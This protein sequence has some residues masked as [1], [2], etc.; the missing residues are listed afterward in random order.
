[1]EGCV[2][3]SFSKVQCMCEA[4]TVIIF[5]IVVVVVVSMS[6]RKRQRS[7]GVH[8]PRPLQ[9]RRPRGVSPIR[10]SRMNEP[11]YR[12]ELY[13][14][15]QN[16]GYPRAVI[17]GR[18][19][20]LAEARR[21]GNYIEEVRDFDNMVRAIRVER[22]G[23]IQR[24]GVSQINADYTLQV[25]RN[26]DA[27]DVS[28]LGAEIGRAMQSFVYRTAT[29]G[30]MRPDSKAYIELL[31]HN[32]R[33]IRS[34]TIKMSE[35]N[36]NDFLEYFERIL[37][38][39]DEA[40]FTNVVYRVV[41]MMDTRGGAGGIERAVPLND[42]VAQVLKKR[43]ILEIVSTPYTND[44]FLQCMCL[45]LAD[46]ANDSEKFVKLKKNRFTGATKDRHRAY[47]LSHEARILSEEHNL[48]HR[49]D[50]V[51]F[52]DI[53]GY[54]EK[55]NLRIHVLSLETC[56][57][58]RVSDRE[59][60]PLA[61]SVY[62][63]CFKVRNESGSA[64]P[65]LHYSYI[66]KDKVHTLWNKKYFC[67]KCLVPAAEERQ[68][69]CD[70]VCQMCRDSCC[71]GRLLTLEEFRG[72]RCDK[73]EMNGFDGV[74][75]LKHRRLKRCLHHK[76]RK[77]HKI[78][79]PYKFNRHECH[80]Y[81]CSKCKLKISTDTTHHCAIRS[82][83]K[84]GLKKP[85]QKYIYYDFE[86]AFDGFK[87][88][89][90]FAVAMYH[91]SPEPICFSRMEEFFKW[92]FRKEHEGYTCIAH[93]GGRYDMHFVKSYMLKN[94][95]GSFDVIRGCKIVMMDT[96][97]DLTHPDRP[98]LRFVDS[99]NFITVGLRKFEKTFGLG[100]SGAK[101]FF[102]YEFFT[103]DKLNYE[104]PIPSY[105]YF[106]TIG[107]SEGDKTK[108][109]AW[110]AEYPNKDKYNIWKEMRDY[111]IS[112][113]KVLRRGCQVFRDK[114]LEVSGNELDPF[115]YT[116]IASV[117]MKYYKRFCLEDL[118]VYR[119]AESQEDQCEHVESVFH[120]YA[121]RRLTQGNSMKKVRG[122]ADMV[123]SEFNYCPALNRIY[124]LLVCWRDGCRKCYSVGATNRI[125][126]VLLTTHAG[127]KRE[128]RRRLEE[129]GY[130]VHDTRLCSWKVDMSRYEMDVEFLQRLEGVSS[131]R[132]NMREAFFGGRTEPFKLWKKM[133]DDECG[134][135]VDYTSL[136]PYV[137]YGI[138]E[139]IGGGEKHE[140]FFPVGLPEEKYID[141]VEDLMDST[142]KCRFFGIVKC[143]VRPPS[144]L[145][146][147]LLP[148][149]EDS[150][151]R[152][153]L[154]EKT[155]TWSTIELEKAVELGYEI[156]EVYKIMDFVEKRSTLFRSYVARF[157]KMKMCAAGWKKLLG[158]NCD[159]EE[160]RTKF[161]S[162]LVERY[163]S[164]FADIEI[165]DDYNP[166]LY[167]ISKLCLN[168]LWGKFAQKVDHTQKKDVFSDEEFCNVVFNE[169]HEILGVIHHF[170][171]V[172]TVVYKMC[173]L[174]KEEAGDT[175]LP[176]AIFTTAHARLRLYEALE[177]VDEAAMYCD[178]DSVIYTEDRYEERK[179]PL[180]RHLG[181]LTDELED[182]DDFI[183]EF[184]SIGPK[185]YAYKTKKG[186][187]VCKI[188]G[189]TLR[190][191]ILKTFNFE[192]LR[193][194]VVESRGLQLVG[195]NLQFDID[196]RS[197]EISTRNWAENPYGG[198]VCS[199]TFNKRKELEKCNMEID[200]IPFGYRMN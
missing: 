3:I 170:G 6:S 166:G 95:I 181:Q 111:C 30:T 106:E 129:A 100:D 168:S 194:M 90:V 117:C 33:V 136:Y 10:S 98:S 85:S 139:P 20:T 71:G 67:P 38:Y 9:R 29:F 124:R 27:S 119:L 8:N 185:S 186:K 165:G 21:L 173:G 199:F 45:A 172:R 69:R 198:K 93:N 102:P 128:E 11:L 31:R 155:G 134:R 138:S 107:M 47:L 5:L 125:T 180:G 169:A 12:N 179:L 43:S 127:I 146:I 151:L 58:A 187:R 50:G 92:L 97:E 14:T 174:V 126:G 89:P 35:L 144:D 82:I 145:Y 74:C 154:H 150:M 175:S 37:G 48:S 133:K 86:C 46:V 62:I 13:S 142:G 112:D 193:R 4:I 26:L 156:V 73:C 148:C 76:C 1:M 130:T 17:R 120:D 183:A 160:E 15:A 41:Y 2:A 153:D 140:H 109:R 110:Y 103:I 52:G 54:E 59:S 118:T 189:F 39:E 94:H 40:D 96:K 167:F 18:T 122:L 190:G 81:K 61:R 19:P 105:N 141:N 78:M 196:P 16:L 176:I 75:M 116:T 55:L 192:S 28:R 163:G 32:G 36:A 135:Y 104:G 88:V 7:R 24:I 152:F 68:H 123:D 70:Y 188:K 49:S 44:C 53:A 51:G 114:F 200:T 184:V 157:L 79:N 115:Q 147:P 195:V 65:V 83:E 149:R 158:T 161:I 137:Q 56:T 162:E 191:D 42:E 178:T 63:G 64:R 164:E 22:H 99:Y 57:F 84:G 197:H 60:V 87:H 77:C 91:M 131:E 171:V 159:N 23:S 66:Q 143:K 113:V 34:R 25:R 72:E 101:G 132:I 121:K 182:P 177:V 108:L 80:V